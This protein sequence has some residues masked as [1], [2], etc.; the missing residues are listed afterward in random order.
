MIVLTRELAAKMLTV[1]QR[2]RRDPRGTVYDSSVL[3]AAQDGLP[4]FW[5]E[6]PRNRKGQ[7]ARWVARVKARARRERVTL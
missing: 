4:D 1:W 3:E 2:R 5:E 6:R 7:Y